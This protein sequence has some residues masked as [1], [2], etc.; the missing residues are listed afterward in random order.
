MFPVEEGKQM[1]EY[2]S[3]QDSILDKMDAQNLKKKR[4]KKNCINKPYY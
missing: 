2:G 3:M 1:S 4:K